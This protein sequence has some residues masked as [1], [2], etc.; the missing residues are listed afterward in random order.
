MYLKHTYETTCVGC[1][2]SFFHQSRLHSHM[3]GHVRS[4]ENRSWTWRN[5]SFTD[6]DKGECQACLVHVVVCLLACLKLCVVFFCVGFQ[7]ILSLVCFYW[8]NVYTWG[9][10]TDRLIGLYHVSPYRY[11]PLVTLMRQIPELSRSFIFCIYFILFTYFFYL[12][13]HTP[14]FSQYIG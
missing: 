6:G 7:R 9:S 3:K 1:S 4:V 14:C 10:Q 2:P 5:C 13:P 12:S 11:W 8:S